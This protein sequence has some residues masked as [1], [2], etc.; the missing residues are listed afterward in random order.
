MK[1]LVEPNAAGFTPL[2]KAIA[3][4]RPEIVQ[5]Y[6]SLLTQAIHEG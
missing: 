5:A 4:S 1:V 3:S 2:H 6:L